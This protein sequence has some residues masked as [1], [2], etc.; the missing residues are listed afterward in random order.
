MSASST[1]SIDLKSLSVTDL[2]ALAY[3]LNILMGR[4]QQN[5]KVVVQELES[6]LNPPTSGDTLGSSAS[7]AAV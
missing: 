5:L 3:D 1:Q 4:T 6:R 7:D 2:K